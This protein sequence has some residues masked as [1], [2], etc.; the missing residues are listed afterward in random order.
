MTSGTRDD[1]PGKRPGDRGVT[2]QDA[3]PPVHELLAQTGEMA[4]LEHLEHHS[5]EETVCR[6]TPGRSVWFLNADGR[7]PSWLSLEYMAQCV[8]VH[9][10]LTARL[11]G[12][13]VRAG[14]LLGSRSLVFATPDLDPHQTLRICARPVRLGELATFDCEVLQGKENTPVASGRLNVLR[15]LDF[16]PPDRKAIDDRHHT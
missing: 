10:N 1:N 4:L 6:A 8:A 7:A 11:L 5:P 3:H 14:L 12:E 9:G 16:T 13:E 2:S 15:N